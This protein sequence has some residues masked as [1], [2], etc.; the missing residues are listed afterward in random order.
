[1]NCGD[2]DVPGVF[3]DLPDIVPNLWWNYEHLRSTPQS[4][5]V[6]N[7]NERC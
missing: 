5:I 6:P 4:G 1:M 2:C 7:R 3:V